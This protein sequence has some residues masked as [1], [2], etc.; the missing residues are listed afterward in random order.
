MYTRLLLLLHTA[1]PL[2]FYFIREH[3]FCDHVFETRSYDNVMEIITINDADKI[4]DDDD[5]D[6]LTIFVDT[7]RSSEAEYW[8]GSMIPILTRGYHHPHH[9]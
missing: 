6:V 7:N 8:C 9:P 3:I 4:D 2:I 5:D 1:L